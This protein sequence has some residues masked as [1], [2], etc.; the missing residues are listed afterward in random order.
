MSPLVVLFVLVLS[1][2]KPVVSIPVSPDGNCGGPCKDVFDN[3]S[4]CSEFIEGGACN[5]PS[6]TCCQKIATLNAIVNQENG[7]RVRICRCIEFFSMYNA[8]RPFVTSRIQELP[9]KCN[10]QLSFPISERMNCSSID[11]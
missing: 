11:H 4:A 2:S 10:T 3:F 6:A 8:S 5:D 9:L 1:I 7:G